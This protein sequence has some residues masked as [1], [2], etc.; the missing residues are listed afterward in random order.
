LGYS[1]ELNDKWEY[2]PFKN[3]YGYLLDKF[4]DKDKAELLINS[5]NFKDDEQEQGC[6][7]YS[8]LSFEPVESSWFE[9]DSLVTKIKTK[10]NL[11]VYVYPH[12]NIYS[13][14]EKKAPF[15]FKQKGSVCISQNTGVGLSESITFEPNTILIEED[16]KVFED[17]FIE[18]IKSI[19]LLSN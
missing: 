16:Y 7:S 3:E 10:D 9:D 17:E 5:F 15:V 1:F 8:G 6:Y 14:L 13:D 2:Q 11:E 4:N 12:Y 18:I 19:E